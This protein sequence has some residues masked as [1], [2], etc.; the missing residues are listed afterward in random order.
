[1]AKLFLKEITEK[2]KMTISSFAIETHSSR[3][4]STKLCKL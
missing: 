2:E 4:I 1:M 3:S